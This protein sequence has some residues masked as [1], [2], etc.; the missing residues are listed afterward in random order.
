MVF[1]SF[2]DCGGAVP[3]RSVCLMLDYDAKCS[4]DFENSGRTYRSHWFCSYR[5]RPQ[6]SSVAVYDGEISF[7]HRFRCESVRISLTI[8]KYHLHLFLWYF[9]KSES[10]IFPSSLEVTVQ[11]V[12]GF[13]L[14]NLN[15][16]QRLH[17]LVS[18]CKNVQVSTQSMVRKS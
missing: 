14:A 15:R 18:V 9:R 1:I 2:Q 3:F 10:R 11:N 12:I 4:N 8:F 17:G 7:T 6:R 5:R 16:P 13:V